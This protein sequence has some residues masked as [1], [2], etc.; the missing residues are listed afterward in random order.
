MLTHA[1]RPIVGFAAYSGT[2]K[3][4]L[5]KQLIPALNR[6]GVRLAVVKHAHHRFD[7]DI[8]GKDSYELRQAGAHQ[9]LVVSARRE[10][11]VVEKTE[12]SDPEL[13]RVLRYLD[14]DAVDMILVEGFKHEAFPKIEL[15][16][17]SLGHPPAYPDDPDIIAVLSDA[18]LPVP[19]PL[20]VL[21]LNAPEPLADF[22]C[23]TF[24]VGV[25]LD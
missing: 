25:A 15:Y 17:A 9:M 19:T 11:L 20:P 12:E 21:D 22:L 2:G 13:D 16:R 6:R 7:I 4:T 8:P 1:R 14:Q 18:T 24:E 23:R 5:L 10:A 3:T